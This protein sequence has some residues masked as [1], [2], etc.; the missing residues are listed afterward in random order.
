MLSGKRSQPVLQKQSSTCVR[1]LLFSHMPADT[2]D[3][4]KKDMPER[5]KEDETKTI[6][7]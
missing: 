4:D 7:K 6:V 1:V 2:S 3:M 5:T